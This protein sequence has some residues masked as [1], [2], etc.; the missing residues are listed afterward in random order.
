MLTHKVN[1]R[2]SFWEPMVERFGLY[3]PL[4]LVVS[5]FGIILAL[6][7]LSSLWFWTL[8]DNPECLRSKIA[9]AGRTTSTIAIC[10]ALL[11]SCIA[12]QLTTCCMMVACLAFEKHCV[13]LQDAAAMSIYRYS[14]NYPYPMIFPV[15][16]GTMVSKN[17]AGISLLILLSCLTISSQ[18]ISTI[19]LS[20]TG[21]EYIAMRSQNVS[22]AYRHKDWIDA[23]VPS[24]QQRPVEFPRFAEKPV[25]PFKISYNATGPAISDTGSTVR[26]LLPLS[27]P[28]RSS[29]LYYRG[30]ATVIDAHVLCV[31]PDIDSLEFDEKQQLVS[32]NFTAPILRDALASGELEDQGSFVKT[33]TTLSPV[34]KVKTCPIYFNGTSICPAIEYYPPG[35]FGEFDGRGDYNF[36]ATKLLAGSSSNQW[37][38]VVRQSSEKT[39]FRV[40][41]TKDFKFSGTEWTVGSVTMGRKADK[42][43]STANI[44]LCYSTFQPA[45]AAIE[46][47]AASNITEPQ[48]SLTAGR[49]YNTTSLRN[50]LRVK[51]HD[52]HEGGI[53]NLGNYKKTRDGNQAFWPTWAQWNEANNTAMEHSIHEIYS[54]IFSE[55]LKE[56]Q[57]ASLALQA[58]FTLLTANGYYEYLDRYDEFGNST[59]QAVEPVIIP[60]SRQGL[61]IVCG[62]IGLHFL[63][64]GLVF[65]LYFFGSNEQ[66]FMDQ[67]WQT[68]GQLHCGEARHFL[69]ETCDLGDRA[70]GRLP[71]AARK[72]NDIVELSKQGKTAINCRT[73]SYRYM[74]SF[75]AQFISLICTQ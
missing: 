39:A 71:Q 46:I 11:R 9:L 42:T 34:F 6:A 1:L 38:L 50:Q 4:A 17:L 41:E 75:C 2:P 28:K 32:G 64:V 58:I 62:F 63:S 25:K 7:A 21:L 65:W 3:Q 12:I 27:A 30:N 22:L 69:D 37:W 45:Y 60:A 16:R 48:Y 36:P 5:T 15:L 44:T 35:K 26:A 13:L 52:H 51:T 23:L 14:A 49:E 74:L 73:T 29:L 68:V 59:I 61:F 8:N 40:Y 19:L 43:V 70:I 72:W 56:T 20:D 53:F 47:N 54:S 18:F 66:K 10:S 57:T 24:L 33:E 55:T 31:S 67:A